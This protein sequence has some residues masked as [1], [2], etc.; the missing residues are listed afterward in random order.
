MLDQTNLD[1]R[2]N[3][4]L[5][6]LPRDTLALLE[7]DLKQTPL[8]EG[9]VCFEAGDPIDQIYFPHSGLVS[10]M[11]PA[12]TTAVEIASIGCEGAA[13]LQRALGRCQSS[14]RACVQIGGTFSIISSMRFEYLARDHQALKDMAAHYMEICLAEAQQSAACNAVHDAASR[15]SRWLLQISDRARTEQVLL[16]QECLA[17]MLGVRRTTVTKLAQY[18]Q[19]LGAIRCGRSKITII[20]RDVLE[21]CSCDCYRFLHHQTA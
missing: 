16:T 13:G 8:A 9:F 10:L 15:L 3:Q 7:R 4:L 18:L 14:A 11:V 19:Q 5:A 17:K 12:G 6:S 20:D 1:L 21:K 2:S